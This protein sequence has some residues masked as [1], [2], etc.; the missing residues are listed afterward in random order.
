M[1][2][3][4]IQVIL[5]LVVVWFYTGVFKVKGKGRIPAILP[6]TAFILGFV[7]IAGLIS[8]VVFTMFIMISYFDS[9]YYELKDNKLNRFLFKT[10]SE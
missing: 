4:V 9:D 1:C 8:F 5:A 6:I 3:I 10:T 7:P 2:L